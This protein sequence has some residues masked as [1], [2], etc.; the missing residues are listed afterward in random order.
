[1][2]ISCRYDP[3][4]CEIAGTVEAGV[5]K[6]KRD[7]MAELEAGLSEQQQPQQ[8]APGTKLPGFVSAGVIQQGEEQQP[9]DGAAA[10]PAGARIIPS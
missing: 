7:D 6:R 9:A 10:A 3:S 2:N 5:G 4:L 8:Q 1:M